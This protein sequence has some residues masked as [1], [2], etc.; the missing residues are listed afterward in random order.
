MKKL[1]FLILMPVF[2]Q[3]HAQNK[4]LGLSGVFTYYNV[5]FYRDHSIIF[6]PGLDIH[7]NF[8]INKK[9]MYFTGFELG[10]Y[11]GGLKHE[12]N[13][14]TYDLKI[15]TWHLSIPLYRQFMTS[16]KWHP[17]IGFILNIPLS[18]TYTYNIFDGNQ[19][20]YHNTDKPAKENFN[21]FIQIQTGFEYRITKQWWWDVQVYMMGNFQVSTGIKYYFPAQT[22]K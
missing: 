8:P 2:F 4:S 20:V 11:A 19:N 13:G 10:H 15:E 6:Q 3:L 1:I 16:E 17:R 9:A 12:S 7:F 21:D 14:I 5:H 18:T 22:K